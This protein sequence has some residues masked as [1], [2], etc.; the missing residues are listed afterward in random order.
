MNSR[1]FGLYR[2]LLELATLIV[3]LTVWTGSAAAAA[4][5][6]DEITG[7]T[8]IT[9]LPFSES[10]DTRDA[11]A[12]PADGGCGGSDDLATVWYTFTPG[13]DMVVKV[14][15]SGSSYSTGVNIFS[16]TPGNLSLIN[17]LNT[18]VSFSAVAGTPYFF[19]VADCCDGDG[20]NGGD[21]V[22]TVDTVPPPAND[23]IADA[24][25]VTEVPF[26][27]GP[28]NTSG[29]TAAG[30]DPQ[31]C[32]NNGSVWYTFTPTAN[33]LI[34]ANTIGSDYDTTLGVYAGSPGSLS[35][36]GCNDDFYGVQSAVRFDATANTTYFFMV[37]FCCGNGESGG[38]TL[39][40]NIRELPAP[41]DITL[42]VASPG[43]FNPQS[44]TATISGTVMCNTE[45]SFT[46]VF[47][48]LRQRVGRDFI[49]GSFSVPTPDPCSPPRVSWSATVSG[50]GVFAGGKV[51]AEV[52]TE[53]CD[54]FSCDSDSVS[55]TI[56]LKGKGKQSKPTQ[57]TQALSSGYNPK[58][59]K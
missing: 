59:G 35:L 31:D 27:D 9:T 50:D 39:F 46:N 36:I 43:S 58:A 52:S 4:P 19:L 53:A 54:E 23:D 2:R 38:G 45:A 17:C 48:T 18:S 24:T 26:A 42:V 33:I 3:L 10:L 6:N 22:L 32:F 55:T 37:G 8:V 20:V 13:T 30:D 47:G 16:G 11:T 49:T 51:T 29:A 44:G 28:I 34:E 1:E 5:P 21:L 57:S 14:D 41:M 25:V 56:Q 15:T 12:D 7:A 40:F